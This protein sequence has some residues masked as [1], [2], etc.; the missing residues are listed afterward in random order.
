MKLG[1]KDGCYHVLLSTKLKGRYPLQADV[2][3]LIIYSLTT[4]DTDVQSLK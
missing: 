3:V 2:S 4:V 1:T